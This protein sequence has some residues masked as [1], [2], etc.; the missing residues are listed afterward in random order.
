MEPGEEGVDGGA[1]QTLPEA[2]ARIGELQAELDARRAEAAEQQ[3]RLL[4]DRAEAENWKRRMQREKAESLRYASEAL[5]RDLL[6][7]IDN[8]GRAVRAAREADTP[9]KP[10]AP[11]AQDALRQG[12]EMVLQQFDDVLSRHGV[13]RVAAKAESFD[14]AH[15]EA[16]AHVETDEHPP[17]AVVDEHLPGYRLHDRLLRAAQV[18]VA[19]PPAQGAPG[20]APNRP[21][22]G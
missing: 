19:K 11:G 21:G 18:T 10:A 7:A 15:H 13:S 12:V 6:P 4:R 1:P 5:L 9:G 16:L 8:L 17:G 14:P 2:M 3:D 22:R 20:A